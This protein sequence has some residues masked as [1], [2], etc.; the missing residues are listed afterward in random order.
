M[1]KDRFDRLYNNLTNA[2]AAL[3]AEGYDSEIVEKWCRDIIAEEC[4]SAKNQ[5]ETA[6]VEATQKY[7]QTVYPQKARL[8]PADELHMYVREA[9][10]DVVD[11]CIN[12]T[13]SW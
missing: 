10:V 12:L 13:T 7:I 3:F 8:Y 5:Y 9:I 4:E 1:E 2:V 6:I 11:K